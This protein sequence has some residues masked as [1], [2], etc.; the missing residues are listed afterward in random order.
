[1]HA[2]VVLYAG[3][4]ASPSSV[5]ETFVSRGKRLLLSLNVFFSVEP[6][7]CAVWS[8]L[9]L[10]MALAFW[11]WMI[12]RREARVDLRTDFKPFFESSRLLLRG[13]PSARGSADY[14]LDD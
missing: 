6:L 13:W 10:R 3:E 2:C 1:M 5:T 8:L 11:R 7:L 14:S 12:A 9:L 4:E